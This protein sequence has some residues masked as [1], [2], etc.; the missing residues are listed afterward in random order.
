M[1]R[2]MFAVLIAVVLLP[3]LV[4]S[5]TQTTTYVF[6]ASSNDVVIPFT[7]NLTGDIFV[8]A[9]Y[10]TSKHGMY[11]IWILDAN[12]NWLCHS[13]YDFR[14]RRTPTLP[15]TCQALGVPAG[16]YSVVFRA[17]MGGKVDVTLTVIS[18]MD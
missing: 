6:T 5:A 4:A 13:T 12:D 14:W 11:V 3:V 2:K 15:Q 7:T 17:A 8:S 10:H 16:N 9:R 18:E 1:K